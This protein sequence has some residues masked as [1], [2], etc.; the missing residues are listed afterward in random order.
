MVTKLG[1]FTKFGPFS[2]FQLLKLSKVCYHFLSRCENKFFFFISLAIPRPLP[3]GIH[4]PI[5]FTKK[6]DVSVYFQQKKMTSLNG[7]I[8]PGDS[9]PYIHHY[10][11]EFEY[12]F[13]SVNFSDSVTSCGQKLFWNITQTYTT[14]ILE[15]FLIIWL[16]FKNLVFSISR[17]D[18]DFGPFAIIFST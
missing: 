6:I 1:Q 7:D 10:C 11:F 4:W 12:G 2:K 13:N 8:H 17:L 16:T 15:C 5:N 9:W 18:F 14:L 3:S